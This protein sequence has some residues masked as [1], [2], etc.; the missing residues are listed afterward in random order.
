MLARAGV[1]AEALT[2]GM[3][4]TVEAETRTVSIPA[5]T[6][7]LDRSDTPMLDKFGTDLTALA[8]NGELD[9]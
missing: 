3:R 4:E 1:T 9:P 6:R 7:L 5:P 2:Q 8:E